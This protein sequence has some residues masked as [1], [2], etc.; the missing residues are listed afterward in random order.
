L[1][2]Q[3]HTS[4]VLIANKRLSHGTLHALELYNLGWSLS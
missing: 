1:R 2:W 3:G 4:T